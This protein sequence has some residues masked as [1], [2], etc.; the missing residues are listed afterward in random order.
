MSMWD[1]NSDRDYYDDAHGPYPQ[2]NATCSECGRDFHLGR[3]DTGSL[4]DS[5]CSLRDAIQKERRMHTEFGYA[6]QSSDPRR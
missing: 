1:A 3:H 2:A 6:I 4:C 5:C